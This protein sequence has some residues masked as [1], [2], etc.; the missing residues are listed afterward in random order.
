[1][2]CNTYQ[3][4]MSAWLEN[5]LTSQ[6]M[7][8][9]EAH[10]A[11]CPSCRAALDALRRVDWLLASAPMMSPGPGFT[12]RFQAKLAAHRRRRRTWAGLLTLGLTTLAILL[13]AMVL[14]AIS[15]MAVWGNLS[16][17]GLLTQSIGL[18]LDLG[19]VMMATVKVAWLIL[20]ALAQGVRHPAFIAYTLATA[21]LVAAWTQIVKHRVLAHQPVSASLAE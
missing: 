15:G 16:T 2:E 18:L 14:V 21:I 6:E 3:E 12:V 20:S 19:K 8:G 13:G 7:Q 17:S 1:M 9:V 10:V 4:Q 5:Q 11:V